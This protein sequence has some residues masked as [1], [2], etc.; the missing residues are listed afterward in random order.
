MIPEI[1]CAVVISLGF[2]RADVAC[3]NM[4]T[5]VE[6]SEKN[7]HSPALVVALIRVESRYKAD[8]VS[9]AN[10]CGLMQVLPKYTKNPK[11]SCEQLKNPNVNIKT[12]TKKLKFWIYK[13]GR[14]NIRTGLCGYN[15]GFRCKGKN[16]NAT[17]M[18]YAKKVLLYER[19]VKLEYNKI[20]RDLN[21]L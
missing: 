1:L 11:L 4:K 9:K 14:G 16:K 10:A 5:I 12:G 7:D 2:P 6:E 19:K 15:A 17:G 3:D 8:A 18:R 13:Y 20:F 21:N